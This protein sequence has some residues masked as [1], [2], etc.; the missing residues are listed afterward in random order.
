MIQRHFVG[1]RWFGPNGTEVLRHAFLLLILTVPSLYISLTVPPLWRD[2]DAFNEIASTFA[3]RGIIHYL[4][5]YSLGGRLIVCAGS[6]VGSL[7]GGRGIPNLSIDLPPLNDAGIY[8]LVIAQHL[9]L[10]LSLWFAV[11]TLSQHFPLRA[12]FAMC[13]ALT[14]FLYIYA[15]CIGSEAFSNPLIYLI[16]ACGWNCIRTKE[17]NS[18]QVLICFGL[19]V[20]AAL[21]RQINVVLAAALPIALLPLTGKELIHLGATINATNRESRFRYTRLFLIFVVVGLSAIGTSLIVQ[22]TLCW[23]YRVPFRSTFGETFLYRLNYFGILPEQERTAILTAIGAKV[24]D[25]VVT[26]ALEALGRSL[27]QG[28]RWTNMFLYYKIDE[29]LLRNGLGDKEG[30]TWQIHL[31]L[32]RIATCVLLSG[33]PNFRNTVW[34]DFVLSPFFVQADL[35]YPPFELTDWVRQQLAYPRYERMRG[36]ASFQHQ[37]GYYKASW[38]RLSYAHLFKRVP[39]LEMACLAVALTITLVGLGLISR[40][41]DAVTEAGAWYAGGLIVTGL[42]VSFSTCLSTYF[43]GRLY[44]PVYSLFQM[45]MLL[46]VAMA[47]NVLRDRVG[48]FKKAKERL[49]KT[50]EENSEMIR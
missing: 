41:R 34:R 2:E 18:R 33:E 22:Q 36:L 12:L 10:I 19:L 5:G 28:E 17:L 39:M 30:R 48:S 27:N 45:G 38:L 11:R 4:P 26:E 24:G 29:I 23:F 9:F 32:N 37:E 42:L 25:P 20:A 13:F 8:T 15:N 47:A 35:A 49:L 21:T 43:Q 14:P 46:A 16:T 3:P 1:R 6:I 50:S 40:P 31:K 44:L 7:S